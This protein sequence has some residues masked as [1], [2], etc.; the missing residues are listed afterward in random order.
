MG[1]R[2]PE[3]WAKL[4]PLL[5]SALEHEDPRAWLASHPPE[6]P[7]LLALALKV[8]ARIQESGGI[9]DQSFEAVARE[10][11]H[12]LGPNLVPGTRLGPYVLAEEIGRGGMGVVHR[13]HRADGEFQDEVV[14][15]LMPP[16]LDT[17]QRRARFLLERQLL[18]SLRHPRIAQLLDGGFTDSGQPYLVLEY[19]QGEPIDIAVEQQELGL[20]ARLRLFLA[21]L[22]AV[23]HAHR[24]LVVHRDLKPSN[25][26]VTGDGHVKLLDFGI[27]KVIEENEGALSLTGTGMPLMTP[28]YASPEQVRGEAITTAVDVYQL[29]LLLYLLLT[30][31]QPQRDAGDSVAG[32]ERAVCRTE[33][34]LPSSACLHPWRRRLRGDLD[35]I[36][37]RA[38]AKEP[39]RRYA[40]ADAMAEDLRRHLDGRPILASGDSAPY[41][42][43]K[44]ISRHQ[45]LAATIAA[46]AAAVIVFAVVDTARVRTERDRAQLEARQREE[47]TDLLVGLFKASGDAP[48]R[49]EEVT[50][51]ELLDRGVVRIRSELAEQPELRARMLGVIGEAATNVGLYEQAQPLLE[52]A[53]EA[54]GNSSGLTAKSGSWPCRGWGTFSNR[55]ASSMRRRARGPRSWNWSRP[56]GRATA[57][58]SSMRCIAGAARKA[59]SASS[60]RANRI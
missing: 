3:I 22:E 39:A 23:A 50:A 4:L 28:A 7:E 34:A 58:G 25:V 1:E 10:A 2:S 14:I 30:G 17:P 57:P 32:L 37:Q 6:D 21:V 12:D 43:A 60:M 38:L 13:A 49:A 54:C 11:L 55:V 52:E 18:A 40:S 16:A 56:S 24:N 31:V 20:R 29:G 9:L 53:Q 33:I 59:T 45:V 15:K 27:A 48:A 5:D 35:R 41:R 51:R 44:F 19:V 26:L 42:A 47:V 36:L 8:A 46:V